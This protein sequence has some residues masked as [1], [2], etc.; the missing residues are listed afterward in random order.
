MC[1]VALLVVVNLASSATDDAVIASPK[2]LTYNPPMHQQ[3]RSKI[4]ER[5]LFLRTLRN[6]GRNAIN[7]V[8]DR[9]AD[10][11]DSRDFLHFGSPSTEEYGYKAPNYS[12][13][14]PVK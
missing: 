11:Y 2:E 7:Y 5:I 14:Y 8:K 3:R 6:K 9:P 1:L 10:I 13:T 12:Y 4:D